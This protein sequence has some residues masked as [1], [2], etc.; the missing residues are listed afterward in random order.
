MPSM[1]RQLKAI[2]F[3][4]DGTLIESSAVIPDAY[5]DTI[6]ALGGRVPTR[7]QVI[8]AYPVG[9][10][11]AMLTHL[12]GRP[13]TAEEV[14]DYHDRLARLASHVVVYP[15]IE[16]AL[17]SLQDRVRLAVF[18]GASLRAC[19]LLLHGAGLLS[20]FDVLVGADEVERSKPAPDGI[21]LACRRLATDPQDA[22]YVGD[23]PGDLEAARRSGSLAVA[24]AWGHL[25]RAE[26]PADVV[27]DDPRLLRRLVDN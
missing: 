7:D 24:A 6:T 20:F 26:E 14:D 17:R 11:R 15:G 8:A 2:V 9:P 13:S 22:A 23:S 18:T 3:D 16:D 21:H 12:M 4:M 27:V 5:I 1:P 10:P 25:Y 19:R